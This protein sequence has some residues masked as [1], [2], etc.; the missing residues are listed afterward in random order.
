MRLGIDGQ[1]L[2]GQRLGVGRYIEYLVKYWGEQKEPTDKVTLF[3][4]GGNNHDVPPYPGVE[5]A[6]LAPALTGQLWQNLILGRELRKV[7]VLFCPSYTVPVLRQGTFVVATHSIEEAEPGSVSRSYRYTYSLLYRASARRA[8]R[9]IVP[10]ELVRQ[11]VLEFYRLPAEKLVVIPQGADDRFRPSED[12]EADRRARLRFVGTDRPYLVFVGKLSARRSIPLLIEAFSVVV[13]ED[14]IPHALLLL[15]PNHLNLPIREDAERL[16]V[17]DRVVQD[18]G[19][20]AD[21]AE[22]VSAYTAAD[23]YVSAS[24]YE[25][26]SITMV[27]AMACGTPIVAMRRGAVPEVT[28]DAAVLVEDHTAEAL[29]DGLRRVLRDEELRATLR[30]RSLDRAAQFRWSDIA[31]RTLAVIRSVA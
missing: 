2:Q 17:A 5:L 8:A 28:G 30:R 20:F 14:R 23:A 15:G 12:R 22:L 1:R 31:R 3:L 29:A 24:A 19:R 26:F 7:D 13:K 9:V 11:Q 6:P 21:H 4:R 18:D 27:E 25:G 10:S 16:G